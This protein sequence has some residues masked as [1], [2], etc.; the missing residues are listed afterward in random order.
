M[1]LFICTEFQFKE[2][3]KQTKVNHISKNIRQVTSSPGPRRRAPSAAAGEELERKRSEVE[4]KYKRGE[5][6]N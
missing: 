1:P 3:P 2:K 5:V 4:K 6:P